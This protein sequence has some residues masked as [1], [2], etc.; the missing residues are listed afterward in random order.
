MQATFNNFVHSAGNHL[1]GMLGLS[2]VHT[3][4][5][6]TIDNLFW[7]LQTKNLNEAKQCSV[8]GQLRQKGHNVV[9]HAY[10]GFTT[11][12]VLGTDRISYVLPRCPAKREYVKEKAPTGRLSVSPLENLKQKISETPDATHYVVISVGGN[13]FRVNLLN[14]FRLIGDIPQI[15]KRHQEIVDRVQSLGGRN[16]KP[17]LMLQYRIDANNDRPYFIYTIFGILGAVAVAVH[18][19]CIAT[20]VG[21][22]YLFL[23]GKI[24]IEAAGLFAS[25]GALGLYGSQKIVP[26]SVTKN[27]LL[28]NKFSISMLNGMLERFYQP[29]LKKAKEEN[30]PILDLSNTFNPYKPLY[31]SGIEPN[32]AGGKL[33]AE[34]IDHIIRHHDFSGPSKLYAKKDGDAIYKGIEN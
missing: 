18:L 28:W 8:E 1:R 34:G 32:E 16:I 33:I 25:L 27:V 15:Q 11:H 3:L 23:A 2:Y 6:S 9:S 5:D 7:M 30:I 17:I 31:M 4:G 20:L 26:L 14:P 29:L 21:A 19:T 12:S 13:D 24:S 10:D 22:P